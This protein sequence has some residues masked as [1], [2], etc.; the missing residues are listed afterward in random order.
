MSVLIPIILREYLI[1]LRIAI[2]IQWSLKL[3]SWKNMMTGHLIMHH[4]E[5]VT[6]ILPIMRILLNTCLLKLRISTLP[7][8]TWPNGIHIRPK[9]LLRCRWLNHTRSP[10]M[11][12][13]PRACW[14]RL[15]LLIHY[16]SVLT[17]TYFRA[18][19][20]PRYVIHWIKRRWN[21]W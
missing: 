14:L 7:P 19:C 3:W 1:R 11:V 13:K 16:F 2:S 10:S 20:R 8:L 4:H 12:N 15:Y 18:I 9:I 21:N 6:F 17:L 5:R